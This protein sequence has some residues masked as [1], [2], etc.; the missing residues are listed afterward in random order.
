MVRDLGGTMGAEGADLG[1]L[2]TLVEPTRK[3]IE[4]A[5]IY[6]IIKVSELE[7]CPKVQI[8]TIRQYFGGVPP[9]LPQMIGLAKAPKQRMV[10]AGRQARLA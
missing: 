4:A 1:V 10:T 3:M 2:I 5:A 8:W 7:F 6:G 9:K